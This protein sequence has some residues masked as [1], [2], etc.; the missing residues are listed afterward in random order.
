MSKIL[1]N[2][3]E[4]MTKMEEM[5]KKT[6]TVRWVE[7]ENEEE[8]EIQVEITGVM[9]LKEVT[10]VQAMI[11]D[12]GCPKSLVGKEWLEKYMKKY[13][14]KKEDLKKVNCSQK[15]RFRP[16]KVYEA[17]EIV[18]IPIIVKL[19]DIEDS[20]TKIKLG[21][22]VVEAENVPLLCGRN[23]MKDWGAVLDMGKDIM[24]MEIEQPMEIRCLNT[25]GGHLV[26]EIMTTCIWKGCLQIN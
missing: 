6:K 8:K 17:K 22:Y 23:S 20:Y 19:N 9:F 16:S 18:E 11:L 14:L 24:K 7:T 10:E 3:K 5:M 13:K 26:V 4:S 12:T 2:Q 25:S 21:A 1:N 15:F